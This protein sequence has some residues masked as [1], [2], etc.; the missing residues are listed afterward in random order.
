MGAEAEFPGLSRFGPLS[1]FRR[2]EETTT[3]AAATLEPWAEVAVGRTAKA[4]EETEKEEEKATP[5][6]VTLTRE[7][8]EF[9]GL[10]DPGIPEPEPDCL[11]QMGKDASPSTKRKKGKKAM[12]I[13][14]FLLSANSY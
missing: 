10:P 14:Q 8:E 9:P 11:V 1:G 5:S 12:S 13:H 6:M 4:K 7:R 2:R 3:T